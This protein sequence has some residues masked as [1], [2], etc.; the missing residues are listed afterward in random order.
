MSF[1]AR[2][3]IKSPFLT[4]VATTSILMGTGDVISQLTIERTDNYQLKRTLAMS[5]FGLFIA[6]P[7]MV[8]WQVL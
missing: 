2:W 6:G 3:M 7:A 8:Q 1:Y 5:A 4:Q